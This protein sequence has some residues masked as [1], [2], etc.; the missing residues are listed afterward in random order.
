MNFKNDFEGTRPS[1][2]NDAEIAEWENKMN[3]LALNEFKGKGKIARKIFNNG[4]KTT[5]FLEKTTGYPTFL[6]YDNR[7][8]A[9][10]DFT[11]DVT[12][13]SKKRA[14]LEADLR[15]SIS[16]YYEYDAPSYV[17]KKKKKEE[18]EGRID[19]AWEIWRNEYENLYNFL[20]LFRY[21]TNNR[22]LYYKLYRQREKDVLN[23]VVYDYK[24][25]ID[26]ILDTFENKNPEVFKKPSNET[27]DP[28]WVEEDET[29]DTPP[30][31]TG[32]PP[33]TATEVIVDK[34]FTIFGIKERSIID[35]KRTFTLYLENPETLAEQDGKP[36]YKEIFIF[37][38]TYADI[39]KIG[40]KIKIT[41]IRIAEKKVKVRSGILSFP[42]EEFYNT[43]ELIKEADTTTPEPNT[44]PNWESAIELLFKAILNDAQLQNLLNTANKTGDEFICELQ[45]QGHEENL[46]DRSE[47]TPKLK[48]EEIKKFLK[49]GSQT[50]PPNN[51]KPNEPSTPPNSPAPNPT[52]TQEN[53]RKSNEN[54]KEINNSSSIAEARTKAQAEINT[55]F[56]RYGVKAEELSTS[57][58]DSENSWEIYLNKCSEVQLIGSFVNKMKIAILQQSKQNQQA[59]QQLPVSELKTKI[60]QNIEELLK[61]YSQIKIEQIPA[62]KNWEKDL[63]WKNDKEELITLEKQLREAIILASQQKG[64]APQSNDSP[65]P[66]TSPVEKILIIGAIVLS[67]VAIICL[68]VIVRNKRIRLLSKKLKRKGDK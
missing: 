66:T 23:R 29:N 57:L 60:K 21:S 5:D 65:D 27:F 45:D 8:H 46:I 44:T 11:A 6:R 39:L 49:I 55:L 59:K 48:Y 30:P 64:K 63:E 53:S 36:K 13:K 17:F 31:N 62:L 28:L 33:P 34:E 32:T 3:V 58:W 19:D 47:K 26:G 37:A 24:N 2:L 9:G 68:A 7:K 40:N 1:G 10:E 67:V 15:A 50:P 42:K 18:I 12:K 20:A 22:S 43:I 16:N 41:G 14:D 25:I 52:P 54:I 56:E 35:G 51:P 61:K 4:Y 38:K